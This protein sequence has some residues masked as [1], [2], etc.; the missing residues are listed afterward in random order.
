MLANTRERLLSLAVRCYPEPWRARHGDEALE[1]ADLLA[2][3]GV[4]FRSTT[5][6][7]FKGAARERLLRARGRRLAAGAAALVAA[8]S[9]TAMSLLVSVP[10]SPAG[11][12]SV[13]SAVVTNRS[14]AAAELQALFD[15]HHFD[16]VIEQLPVSPSLVGSVL[17]TEALEGSRGGAGI[18][19]Q[20][21]GSCAGGA[22]GCTQGLL[23]PSHFAR[24]MV[25][26]VG[27]AAG[28]GEKY[29][30]AADIFRPGELLAGSGLLGRP[31][32][33]A[34]KALERSHVV[35]LWQV[36]GKKDC[37]V[38]V[39]DSWY[40]VA[41]GFAVSGLAICLKVAPPA[42]ETRERG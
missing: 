10:P 6:S 31:V 13:V 14:D 30:E 27:R 24:H 22:T 41:G 15:A 36:S 42:R 3:D 11:A 29:A 1:L 21:T 5:W 9:L 26:L 25:V 16:I 38:A 8:T 2:Q 28:P 23:L 20:V 32:G 17:G 35:V 37:S 34:L 19:G 12:A 7:Y 39:P 18:L 4:P 40:Q 33:A